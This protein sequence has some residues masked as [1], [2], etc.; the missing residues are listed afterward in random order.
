MPTDRFF[1]SKLL[2]ILC[3]RIETFRQALRE[4]GYVEGKNIVIEYRFAD[5]KA[6]RFPELAAEL[7]SLKVDVIVTLLP[8]SAAKKVT[9]TIPIVFAAVC[10]PVAIGLVDSLARP[11]GNLTGLTVLNPELSGK[12][13]ELLKE[14]S[15]RITRVAFLFGIRRVAPSPLIL[16]ETET[17][18][19]GLGLQIQSLEVRSLNDFDG[20]F[21]AAK[22]EGAFSYDGKSHYQYLSSTDLRFRLEKSTAGDLRSCGRSRS[23]RPY[24]V[25]T[26]LYRAFPP[27][28]DLRR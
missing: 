16:E 4:L 18:S 19:Q 3:A 24:V 7:V 26:G 9:K 20:A 1:R 17:A 8:A 6:D 15:P 12:R 27:S 10:D 13:L 11:G 28:R 23:R 5:G 2:L 14:A 25:W 21:A 22:G